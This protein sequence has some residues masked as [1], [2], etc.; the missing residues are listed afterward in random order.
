MD[1]FIDYDLPTHKGIQYLNNMGFLMFSKYIIR[2]QKAILMLVRDHPGRVIAATLLQNMFVDLPDITDS[3]AFLET[4]PFT[5][6]A[7]PIGTVMDL[8][9]D[10]LATFKVVL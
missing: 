9:L 8:G 3:T 10:D 7:N 2:V 4:N 6:V 1:I 5:R